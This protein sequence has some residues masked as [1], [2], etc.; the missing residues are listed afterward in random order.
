MKNLIT[1]IA[2]LLLILAMFM[3]MTANQRTYTRMIAIDQL[4]NNFKEVA[5]EEG[6]ITDSNIS[7]LKS[8]I[9]AATGIKKQS[10]TVSGTKTKVGRGDEIDYQVS[11]KLDGIFGASNF[12]GV[13][14]KNNTGTYT[15]KHKTTSEYLLEE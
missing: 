14:D 12:W 6:C 10:V 9:S 7:D 5:K 11:V 1:A 13:S 2:S 3:Q 15:I 8:E 4:V